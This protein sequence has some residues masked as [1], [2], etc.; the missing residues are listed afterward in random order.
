MKRTKN[1]T[2][3]K[4]Q[5]NKKDKKDQKFTEMPFYQ[6]LNITKTDMSLKMKF[7]QN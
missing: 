3:T 2:I 4:L 7:H 5:K 6:N 1:T